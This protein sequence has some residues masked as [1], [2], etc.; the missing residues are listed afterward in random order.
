MFALNVF[1]T[2]MAIIVPIILLIGSIVWLVRWM[3]KEIG[4]PE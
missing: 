2:M 1:L 4:N 3:D